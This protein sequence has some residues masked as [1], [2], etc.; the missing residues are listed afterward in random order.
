MTMN[1]NE[2]RA[3]ETKKNLQEAFLKL[4]KKKEISQITIRE[5]TDLAGYNRGTFYLYYH[6]VYDIFEK[7]KEEL[8]GYISHMAHGY[9]RDDFPENAGPEMFHCIVRL[10]VDAYNQY[11]DA[12]VPLLM[13]DITFGESLKQTIL[14]AIQANFPLNENAGS[15]HWQR[16]YIMEYH[17]SAA[18]TVLR[19]WIQN[20]QKESLK[21]LLDF[22]LQI[23][24][25]GPLAM[26]FERFHKVEPDSAAGSGQH[27][28]SE[29]TTSTRSPAYAR[30]DTLPQPPAK[31]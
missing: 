4:Y 11:Q 20:G 16:D 25:Q 23:S 22:L 7:I 5:I 26:L 27:Q 30:A 15:P 21:E 18:L 19:R 13:R 2:Q 1:K 17:F 31:S 9:F 3:A 10:I 14:P 8:L 6:D 29:S 12:M 28:A 24:F